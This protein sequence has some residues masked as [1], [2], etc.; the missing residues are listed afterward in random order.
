MTRNFNTSWIPKV[1]LTDCQEKNGGWNAPRCC[2]L[3]VKVVSR[4]EGF[5]GSLKVNTFLLRVLV[6][7]GGRGMKHGGMVKS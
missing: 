3:V 7:V 6:V 5:E 2:E 1:K 4:W